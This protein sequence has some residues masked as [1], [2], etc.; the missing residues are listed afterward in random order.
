MPPVDGGEAAVAAAGAAEASAEAAGAAAA[1]ATAA[2][3]SPPPPPAPVTEVA[4]AAVATAETAAALA[5]ATAAAAELD[6]S[7]RMRRLE[8]E[9]AEWRTRQELEISS[10]R[11]GQ[12]AIALALPSLEGQLSSIQAMLTERKETVTAE[13]DPATGTVTVQVEEA[14]PASPGSAEDPSGASTE[15]P[16]HR[17]L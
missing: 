6:A 3:Q 14:P 15:N 2:E 17:F 4:V 1:A 16:R 7:E 12:A 8:Q 11:D 5:N 10:L 13:A 9:N